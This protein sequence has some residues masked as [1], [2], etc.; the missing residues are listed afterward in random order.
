MIF[1][2]FFD[3]LTFLV[4]KIPLFSFLFRKIIHLLY[5]HS[6]KIIHPPPTLSPPKSQTSGK[7]LLNQN[8][9]RKK[10]KIKSNQFVN[11][12]INF[13]LQFK[14]SNLTLITIQASTLNDNSIFK[15]KSNLKFQLQIGISIFKS[16]LQIKKINKI[17][18]P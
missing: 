13:Q 17:Q 12:V 5:F 9:P 16:K 15:F 3:L 6:A 11:E 7:L 8:P 18:H 10:E 4:T 2:E 1:S 14:N